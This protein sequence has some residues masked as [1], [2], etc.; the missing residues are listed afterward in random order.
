MMNAKHILYGGELSYFTGKARAYLRWKGVDFEE[1]PATTK[2]YQEIIVP[3][4][5]YAMIPLLITPEDKPMP[6]GC[7]SAHS[8][9]GC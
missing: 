8:I 9:E 3:R 5:G 2:I 1:R 4:V 7:S 6:N